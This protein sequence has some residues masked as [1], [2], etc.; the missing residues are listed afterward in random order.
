MRKK[1]NKPRELRPAQ[2]ALCEQCAAAMYKTYGERLHEHSNRR[3]G[4]CGYCARPAVVHSVDLWP[5]IRRAAM[6]GTGGGERAR[7]SGR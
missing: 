5:K 6:P 7:A 1:E 3:D 4:V 2:M